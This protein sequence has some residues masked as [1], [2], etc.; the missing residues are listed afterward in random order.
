MTHKKTII[1]TMLVAALFGGI[2]LAQAADVPAGTK[3]AEVQQLVKGN[4]S[5]PATL[6]PHKS[7]GDVE[8]AILRDLFEGLVT[9]GPKGEILP[10]VAESWE[11]KDNKHYVFHLRKDAKWSNGDPVTAHDFVFAFQRAVDPNTASPYSWYLEMPTIANATDIIA[12]KKQLDALGVKASDDYTFEV[13]LEKAIPYFVSMLSH[14]TT[15][16]VPKKVIEQF[17]DKWTQPENMVSN[18]AYVLKKWVVNERIELERNKQY[19]DDGKTV[20]NKVVYLPIQSTNAELN[21]YLA[22]ELDMTKNTP[23]ERFKQL[24]KDYPNELKVTGQVS[25]YYYQYNVRKAPFDDVRVRTAL[26]YAIDRDVIAD[27]VMGQGQTPAYGLTPDYVDGFKPVVADWAK[28]TQ[29]ER[30]AKA[31][32]MLKEAGF[33][34]SKP[35]KFELLYNT[36]DNHKKVAVAVASMWKKLGVQV[37]L[38]NQEWKTYLET[39]KQGQFDVSRAGWVA[40][41]NEASSMLDL[42]QSGHGNNDGKYANPAYDKLLSESRDQVDADARNQLYVQAEEILAKDMPIAPIYQYVIPRMVKPYVGGYPANPLDNLYSK[43][44]YIIAH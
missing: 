5:E 27:K 36:D 33:D 2:N 21:R 12:G 17:G 25:T 44:M 18:G 7:E 42:M 35:L 22:G 38:V 24:K 3:L 39:K 23:I 8:S 6:D 31:K 1:N 43:D 28:L 37:S 15:Y 4:G 13:Q 16:P 34:A 20:I 11:T 10:A 19:W 30:D 9:S 14:T 26:S 40:D 32:A 41:Y 29:A